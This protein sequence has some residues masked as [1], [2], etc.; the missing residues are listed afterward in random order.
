M[1]LMSWLIFFF[2]VFF[3]CLIFFERYSKHRYKTDAE[4]LALL[5]ENNQLLSKLVKKE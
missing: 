2:L 3:P 1:D 4:I 5:K